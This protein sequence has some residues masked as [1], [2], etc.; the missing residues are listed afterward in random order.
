M[1]NSSN[2]FTIIILVTMHYLCFKG[3][4]SADIYSERVQVSA[5]PN[6][7]LAVEH[8][9]IKFCTFSFLINAKLT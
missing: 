1:S 7:V 9:W 8:V 6:V 4:A 3:V 5:F 2:L